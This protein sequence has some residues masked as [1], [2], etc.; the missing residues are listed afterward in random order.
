MFLNQFIVIL[1]RNNQ[2]LYSKS[3]SF[4]K[5]GLFVKLITIRIYIGFFIQWFLKFMLK[6]LSMKVF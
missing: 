2:Y 1:I 3:I 4:T 5:I 6:S